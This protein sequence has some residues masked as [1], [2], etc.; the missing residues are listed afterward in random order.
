MPTFQDLLANPHDEELFQHFATSQLA[1]IDTQTGQIE[2]IGP[3]ALITRAEVSPDE[4]YILVSTVRRPFSYRVPYVYFTRKT[5]VWDPT[6]Q[7]VATIA[8]LP[9]SDEVPRQGVPTGPRSVD[10]Q[11]LHEARLI[12]TEALDGGDPRTKVPHRDKVMTLAAPF[13]DKPVEVF[14][15]RHRFSNLA[16]LPEKDRAL[17]TE[18]DRDRRWRTTALIDLNQPETSRKVLFDLSV[19]DDY[20]DPGRPVTVKRP[21]GSTTIRQDGDSIYLIGQGDSPEGSRPFLDKMDLET[22]LKIRLFRSAERTYEL[23]IDF[24]GDSR[25]RILIGH[26]TK[27]EPPNE[28]TVDLETGKRTKLT[29]YRDPA[30]Q[31]TGVKK[32]LIHYRRAEASRSRARS[33]CRRTTRRAPDCPR[34]SG[35]TRWSTTTLRRPARCARLPSCFP[36]CSGRPSYSSS[37]RAMRS[38]RGHD[39]GRWRPRDDERHVH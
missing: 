10:W 7:Q 6:G 16:W 1:R 22:G 38:G 24:V 17:V 30:P 2:R 18:F 23:P 4:R 15:V 39:A 5:Q 32:E 28:F 33:I 20:N 26:Q 19:H 34:S 37:L 13:K 9:I 35:L 25:S 21:D 8:D 3:T 11:P 14:E 27:T 36:D 29:D 12:W 31:L